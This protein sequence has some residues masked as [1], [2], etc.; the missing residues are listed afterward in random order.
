MNFL[1]SVD[2]QEIVKIG[3]EQS[4]TFEGGI[5]RENF[6]KSPFRKVIAK[7][8]A[9]KRKYTDESKDVKQG[10]VK[11]FMK[12]LYGVQKC[13]DIKEFYKC[14]RQHWTKTEFDDDVLDY[15]KLPN[16]NYIVKLKK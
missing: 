8:F 4:Q 2:N 7:T 9:L 5:D 1:T 11:L 12:S 3:A 14:K 10:L 15:W 6:K 16:G 13:K